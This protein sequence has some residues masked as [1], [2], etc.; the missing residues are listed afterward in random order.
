MYIYAKDYDIYHQYCYIMYIY[1]QGKLNCDQDL[2]SSLLANNWSPRDSRI[3]TLSQPVNSPTLIVLTYVVPP[4]LDET[5]SLVE[6][7][8]FI[9]RQLN[10]HG[11]L[12]FLA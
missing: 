4:Y 12:A 7:L 2:I 11:H 9:K 6:A 5:K 3:V 1:A 8:R 10:I